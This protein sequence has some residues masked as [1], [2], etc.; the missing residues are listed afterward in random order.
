[1]RLEGYLAIAGI[2]VEDV[3]KKVE[4]Y[5]EIKLTNEQKKK[6]NDVLDWMIFDEDYISMSGFYSVP[7]YMG[8]SLAR[9]ENAYAGSNILRD[10][11]KYRGS[12]LTDEQLEEV[13]NKEK[14]EAKSI[15][16]AEMYKELRRI[17]K[18]ENSN[19]K[20]EIIP[21]TEE[22]T[23]SADELISLKN[24]ANHGLQI[25]CISL[26]TIVTIITYVSVCTGV[27]IQAI[28]SLVL[29][30][31]LPSCAM[32]ISKAEDRYFFLK[33]RVDEINKKTFLE[34]QIEDSEKEQGEEE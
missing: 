4:R 11:V 7:S 15:I 24:K 27:P 29:V 23:A 25:G 1:M 30:A 22:E 28:F 12:Y 10:V 6:I 34:R 14:E 8:F 31:G 3:Y 16:E 33:K 20:K 32:I 9:I 19:L 5:Y 13:V 18:N 17:E 26:A 21:D 2:T